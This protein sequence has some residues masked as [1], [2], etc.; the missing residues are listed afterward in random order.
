[1][2]PSRSTSSCEMSVSS[3]QFALGHSNV[4]S[5]AS[6]FYPTNPSLNLSTHCSYPNL[7]ARPS[8][9]PHYVDLF[10]SWSYQQFLISSSP[11]SASATTTYKTDPLSDKTISNHPGRLTSSFHQY[12]PRLQDKSSSQQQQQTDEQYLL[13]KFHHETVVHLDTGES[14]NIQQITSK[15]FL[16]SAK[17]SPYYSR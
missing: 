5:V 3:P 17:L 9:S 1:M 2:Y 14:K 16:D 13:G 4:N 11:P 10:R 7:V 8:S 15:D 6:N 12:Y